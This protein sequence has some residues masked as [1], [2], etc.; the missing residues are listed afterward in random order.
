MISF[1]LKQSRSPTV[2]L[3]FINNRGGSFIDDDDD[4]DVFSL[5]FIFC[6]S[7]QVVTDNDG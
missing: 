5:F 1:H 6:V 7:L 4:D 2:N 3:F